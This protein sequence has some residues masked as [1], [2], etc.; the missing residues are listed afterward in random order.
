MRRTHRR[1]ELGQSLVEF[2]VSAPVLI[3]LLLGAFDASVMMSDKVIAG[4]ACRQ[5]ARLAAEIGGQVTNPTLTTSVVDA[6]I[7]KNVIAVASAMNYSTI[8]RIYIYQPLQPDG[9]FHAGDPYDL[10]DAAGNN[11][12]QSFPITARNQIPP[13][14]TPIGVRVDWNYNPPTGLPGFNLNLSEHAV[15]RA[16]P[17]LV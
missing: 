3:L 4:A 16:S 1:R 12:Y 17:V 8:T 5:G 13:N 11:L 15:F 7:V 10:F 14:E 2:A 6:N 9:D